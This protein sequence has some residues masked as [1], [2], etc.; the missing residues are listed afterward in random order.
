MKR[1]IL[2]VQKQEWHYCTR[3]LIHNKQ[4]SVQL[5]IVK[6]AAFRHEYTAIIWALWVVEDGRNFGLATALLEKAEEIA[7]SLGHKE[8]ALEWNIRDSPRWVF[9]WYERRGYEE[10]FFSECG[11]MMFKQIE[12]NN[13]N[14]QENGE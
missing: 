9:H 11:S 4:G 13:N 8:V 3:Y 5:D 10:R 1:F 7:A 14:N 2:N 6:P 12:N